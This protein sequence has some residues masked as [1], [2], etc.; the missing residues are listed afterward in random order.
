MKEYWSLLFGSVAGDSKAVLD[1]SSEL[2]GPKTKDQRP[3][4]IFLYD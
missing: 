3:K 2:A 1:F 4:A